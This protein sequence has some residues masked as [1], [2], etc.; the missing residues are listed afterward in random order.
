M[1]AAVVAAWAEK[2]SNEVVMGRT[3]RTVELL[4]C[5]G[6]A[7]RRLSALCA[8][9]SAQRPHVLRKRLR[10]D[11][12]A[13]RSPGRALQLARLD[14]RSPRVQGVNERPDAALQFG[15]GERRG[16]R[17]SGEAGRR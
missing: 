16:W 14:P 13:G 5:L 4:D 3:N 7:A 9:E 11:H 2:S 8:Q 15:G 1:G 12:A 17:R 6:R 10:L